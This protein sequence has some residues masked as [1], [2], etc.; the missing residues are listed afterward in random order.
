M[1]ACPTCNNKVLQPAAIFKHA[2]IAT[3]IYFR[4]CSHIVDDR[5]TIITVLGEK[6]IEK[7][8]TATEQISKHK[9]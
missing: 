4:D 5:N 1:L 9:F 7:Q 3:G 6:E 8:K 2:G